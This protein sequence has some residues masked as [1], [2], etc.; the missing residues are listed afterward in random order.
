MLG[1]VPLVLLFEVLSARFP[2]YF[3]IL[4][5]I[6]FILIVYVIPRGVVGLFG[7]SC[8]AWRRIRARSRAADA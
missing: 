1:V 6:V 2:N 3:S 8:D 4:L 7:G 5:G